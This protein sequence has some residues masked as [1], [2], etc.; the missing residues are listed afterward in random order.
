MKYINAFAQK[1][2]DSCFK[3]SFY[4]E[5][6]KLSVGKAVWFLF[7]VNLVTIV[8]LA[9]PVLVSVVPEL[10][11]FTKSDFVATNYPNGLVIT[12][13]DGIASINEDSP[14]FIPATDEKSEHQN[15]LAIDTTEGLSVEEAQ[16]YDAYAVLMQKQVVFSKSK[17]ETRIFSLTD[18]DDVLITK[19]K[20][21]AWG[22]MAIKWGYI[23]FVPF[24]LVTIG[25]IA[26][27]T[28]VYYLVLCLLL[29]LVPFF[30][31]KITKKAL[32]YSRSYK[33]SLYAFV[34][35]TLITTIFELLGLSTH[36]FLI[37]LVTF[38][39]VVW[40][41]LQGWSEATEDTLIQE[42]VA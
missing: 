15:F 38:V 26:G 12:V 34:P 10:V 7:L 37:T 32:T 35:V 8:I 33:L 9:I 22:E 17:N 42:T 21:I 3:P 27:V 18:T 19:E 20:A 14:Y 4:E 2:K 31:G 24:T 30:V 39:V 29:A 28:L 23:L 36:M 11:D 5:S 6:T 40:T 13:E 25:L 1:V 41:N 16:A